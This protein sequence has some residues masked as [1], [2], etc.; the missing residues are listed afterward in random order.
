M[1]V[2][3]LL[4]AGASLDEARHIFEAQRGLLRMRG[5]TSGMTRAQWTSGRRARRATGRYDT[6]SPLP[7]D[8]R[9]VGSFFGDY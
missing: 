4:Y 5:A 1:H 6:L 2:E 9:S 8:F 7:I 3:C